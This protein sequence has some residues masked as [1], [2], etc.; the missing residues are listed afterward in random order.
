M[1]KTSEEMEEMAVAAFEA[2]DVRRR[3]EDAAAPV[4]AASPETVAAIVDSV[5]ARNIRTLIEWGNEH[6][7]GGT[8]RT[9]AANWIEEERDIGGCDYS[10]RDAMRAV[11]DW[12]GTTALEMAALLMTFAEAE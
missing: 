1:T 8:L 2:I 3:L 4:L 6:A 9:L 10:R 5:L 11:F 7:Q 12:P